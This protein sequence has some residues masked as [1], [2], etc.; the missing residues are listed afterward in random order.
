MKNEDSEERGVQP[1]E[2]LQEEVVVQEL[3]MPPTPR[4]FVQCTRV[5]RVEYHLNSL[6]T[7]DLTADVVAKTQDLVMA[8]VP[9]QEGRVEGHEPVILG[10]HQDNLAEVGDVW[11]LR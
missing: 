4:Q 8:E 7:P 10:T 3:N 6:Q 5:L 1:E 9:L 11:A 2:L